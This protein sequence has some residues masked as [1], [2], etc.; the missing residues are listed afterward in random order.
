M[1]PSLEEPNGSSDKQFRVLEYND[2]EHAGDVSLLKVS[3]HGYKYR[4]LDGRVM[5]PYVTPERYHQSRTVKL[6]ETDIV[7]SSYPK[8]GSTWLSYI[9]V[10]LTGNKGSSLRDSYHWIE[11]NWLYPRSDAYL[12]DARDPRIFASHMPYDM[13]VGGDPAKSPCKYVYI[14]RNPKDVCVSYYH[15]ESKKSWSGNYTGDWDHW[16][17]M[18]LEGK[19][20]RG[21]WFD[22]VLGW[23]QHRDADNI[24]FLTYER[25][26]ED[27]DGELKKLADFLGVGDQLTT[28]KLEEIKSQINFT[29]MKTNEFSGLG[30]VK[31]LG[32]KFFRK[33]KVGSWKEQF[34]VQQSEDFDRLWE[35]RVG[36]EK[37]PF[38]FS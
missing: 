15:F 30:D 24:L 26:K 4:L 17:Q 6:R 16:L 31:E 23:W 28:E 12:E 29:N 8:S 1:A 22:H 7:Y 2:K 9:L 35:E 32:S 38:N 5:P 20:Q 33:G 36:G 34:T 25:L 11:N 14:A 18:F 10:L 37:L 21:D 13:A 27:I 19:V 3:D